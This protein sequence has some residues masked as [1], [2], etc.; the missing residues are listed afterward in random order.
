MSKTIDNFRDY[1]RSDLELAP[2]KLG[3]TVATVLNIL[4]PTLENSRIKVVYRA[5]TSIVVR[6][7]LNELTQS[8]LNIVNNAKDVILDQNLP[9]GRIT[10]SA[11]GNGANAWLK[12]ADNGGGIPPQVLQ[13]IFDPYFTTKTQGTGLGLYMSKMLMRHMS[14]AP[15]SQ[16]K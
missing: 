14:A 8:I 7:Y 11:G 5:A 16:A 6:G 13:K 15:S 1:F 12:I 10:I 3:D 4:G 9:E 2:F